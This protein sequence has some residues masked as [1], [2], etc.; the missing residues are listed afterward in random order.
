M[1]IARLAFSL[2]VSL[3]TYCNLAIVFGSCDQLCLLSRE[4]YSRNWELVLHRF[5]CPT[6]SRSSPSVSIS[7][8][9][10]SGSGSARL[11]DGR[12]ASTSP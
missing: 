2:C 6:L 10:N 7:S 4:M 11:N 8:T 5:I 12:E 9:L 1:D 3:I